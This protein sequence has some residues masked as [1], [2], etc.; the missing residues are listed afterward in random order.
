MS[1][2]WQEERE[3]RAR[4]RAHWR[5][6]REAFAAKNHVSLEHVSTHYDCGEAFDTRIG[7]LH[8]SRLAFTRP[9]VKKAE[10]FKRYAKRPF[11][12]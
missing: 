1:A 9:I 7:C 12:G 5:E 3:E 2:T 4:I 6:L 10:P 8:C 11:C